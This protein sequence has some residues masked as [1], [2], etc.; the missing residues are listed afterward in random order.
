MMFSDKDVF[1]VTRTLQNGMTVWPG[2]DG[3]VVGR[4][5]SISGGGD[6]NVSRISM[7]VHSGTHM[8]APLHFIDG[9]RDISEVSLYK[10]FGSVYVA[11]AA[12]SIIDET[13]FEGIPFGSINAVFFKTPM[14]RRNIMETF[15]SE[16]P[17]MTESCARFLIGKKIEA[18]GTDC[19]SVDFYSDVQNTV[20]HYLLSH[21]AAIIENLCLKDIEPGLY[22]YICLPLRIK[23]S[24][25]APCRVLLFR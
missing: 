13:V 6:V 25:G 3:V 9:G 11:E 12:G 1:D 19:F 16:Y 21:N 24:D 22:D 8:D 17:A 18:V 5:V 15:Y 2:D 20:H 10:L 23:D 4:T 7:G 14:S